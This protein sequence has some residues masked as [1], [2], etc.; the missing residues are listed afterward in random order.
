MTSKQRFQE[1]VSLRSVWLTA[2]R[3]GGAGYP[4][5]LDGRGGPWLASVPP[6]QPGRPCTFPRACRA[7]P[8]AR[9]APSGRGEGQVL[10]EHCRSLR[11]RERERDSRKV[12]ASEPGGQGDAAG[13]AQDGS[14]GMFPPRTE[15][16]LPWRGVSRGGRAFRPSSATNTRVATSPPPWSVWASGRRPRLHAH[17]GARTRGPLAGGQCVGDTS[18][19]QGTLRCQPGGP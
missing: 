3:G 13:G 19:S 7:A 16:G 4:R 15:G 2:P 18:V 14:F 12:F 5:S 8:P 6:A 10:R 1:R 9:A 17:G 11:G